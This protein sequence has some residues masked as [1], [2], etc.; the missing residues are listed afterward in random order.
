[1]YPQAR[2]D[3]L[4]WSRPGVSGCPHVGVEV[5]V[6]DLERIVEAMLLLAP[7]RRRLVLETAMALLDLQLRTDGV[8]GMDDL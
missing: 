7:H 5:V 4:P 3:P 2:A 1:M 6:S 8:A